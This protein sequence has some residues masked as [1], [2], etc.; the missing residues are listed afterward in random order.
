MALKTDFKNAEYDGLRKYR[1]IENDDG[2]V[3]FQDVTDYKTVGSTWGAAEI[4][5][6]NTEINSLKPVARSGSYND[7]TNRPTIPTI[8]SSLPANGGTANYL[9]INEIAANTD[10]NSITT[11]GFY[12]CPSNATAATLTN[13][14]TDRAFFLIVGKS[15]SVYQ[16]VVE[17]LT[18]NQK[19]YMRNKYSSTWGAWVRIYTSADPQPSVAEADKL[20][21]KHASDLVATSAVMTTKE[22]IAA[23][24]NAANVAGAVAVKNIT[25]NLQ[26][27]YPTFTGSSILNFYKSNPNVIG[28]F[29]IN[30]NPWPTD[31][32]EQI[33]GAVQF[34]RER[35]TSRT[36]VLYW[37]FGIMRLY[38]RDFYSNN[39]LN[40]W[41]KLY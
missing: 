41:Q 31:V 28:C 24:T 25:D 33:E 5:A 29:V 26:P 4:N 23:N 18:S 38:K 1:V 7:L 3:S 34:L 22:Q 19:R 15:N 2:T 9:N 27:T 37:G 32:P 17:F 16:E 10:L 21:G 6:T 40:N 30:S 39:Y 35:G 12:N 13:S 8:P 36:V 14:P 20:D 11:P